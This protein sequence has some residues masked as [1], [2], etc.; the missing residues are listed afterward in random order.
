MLVSLPQATIGLVPVSYSGALLST[1]LHV[2]LIPTSYNRHGT[3][4]LEKSATE[5]S[6]TCHCI[7][8]TQ[9]ANILV[10]AAKLNFGC[11]L[12]KAVSLGSAF[13]VSQLQC[14]NISDT[15]SNII[16]RTLL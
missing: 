2:S 13:L 4:Q 10:H 14:R 9:F 3:Y 12:A 8:F 5:H 16:N 15:L 6:S 11:C 7:R 1:L